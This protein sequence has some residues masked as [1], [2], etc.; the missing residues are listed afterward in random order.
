MTA[1]LCR[2]FVKNYEQTDSPTVRRAYGTMAGV[3]CV[4]LNLLLALFKMAIGLLSGAL[5]VTA[6]GINNLSDAGAQ[7]VSLISFRISAKPPDRAHPFGHARI[8]YVASL[9]LSVVIMIVGW[10]LF[11]TSLGT[12]IDGGDTDTVGAVSPILT[13]CVLCGS[14]LCKFWMFLFNRKIA[15]RISSSVMRAAAQDSLSDVAATGAVL[16]GTLFSLWTPL[17]VDAWLG[18]GVSVMIMIGGLRI[19]NDNKNALLGKAPDAETLGKIRA[20]MMKTP[21]ILGVHDITVHSYGAGYS[22]ITLHAEVDGTSTVLLAH[23][24]VDSAERALLCEL[25][26]VATVHMD[27]IDLTDAENARMRERVEQILRGIDARIGM[28]DFRCVRTGNARKLVFDIT[29][30]YEMPYNDAQLRD[31]IGYRVREID[32]TLLSVITVDRE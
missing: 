1:F 2:L 10:E 29:V 12:L 15:T 13:V 17:R 14:I 11:G 30:P 6:D 23:E 16:V 27:P 4:I 19:L 18:L 25:G 21:G 3:V 28:H 7:T 20:V 32:G 9:L 5:S 24:A 8:E 31:M 22:M 26:M